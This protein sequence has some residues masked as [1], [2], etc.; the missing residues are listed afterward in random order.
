M[1]YFLSYF[2]HF[3]LS[4]LLALYNLR[5]I[6]YFAGSNACQGMLMRY[7]AHGPTNHNVTNLKGSTTRA[8][9]RPIKARQRG[10]L[11]IVSFN[12]RR[13]SHVSQNASLPSILSKSPRHVIRSFWR[14]MRS[15]R[16]HVELWCFG[17]WCFYICIASIWSMFLS[18]LPLVYL[19]LSLNVCL[20][21][22]VF[23]E[24]FLNGGLLFSRKEASRT[25]K[26]KSLEVSPCVIEVTSSVD[27]QVGVFFHVMLLPCF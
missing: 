2:S 4:L 24:P 23:L 13:T 12:E 19:F 21:M 26:S 22:L 25:R 1:L 20:G 15:R 7:Q 10:P 18:S 11:K 17:K 3:V 5:E 6:S 16:I 8:R 14:W 27:F 9:R